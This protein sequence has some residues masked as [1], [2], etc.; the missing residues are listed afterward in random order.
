MSY[1]SKRMMQIRSPYR[2]I[3]SPGATSRALARQRAAFLAR[4]GVP[5]RR[6]IGRAFQ[7]E[8]KSVDTTISMA[9][10]QNSAV[11]LLN[12][13]ARGDEINER[14]GRK[15][16]MRSIE[17]H[18]YATVTPATGTDQRQRVL[19]IYDKQTNGAALTAAN[20]LQN[21][22]PVGLRN[23]ENRSRFICLYD[24]AFSLNATGESDSER[25]FKWYRK[26]NL[27]VTFNSGDAGTVADITTGSLY[28]VVVG[29]NV[30]G[31]TAG[32]VNGYVRVRYT[33]N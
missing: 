17:M 26:V 7:G 15:V 5:Q 12:G 6:M 23:L 33:D 8:W 22:S 25:T 29:S 21:T 14:T 13:I 31:A 16:Q 27:T 2:R 10:D 28:M 30:A 20:V 1:V 24:E 19:V 3:R 11:Q 4:G 32:S 9:A 18:L